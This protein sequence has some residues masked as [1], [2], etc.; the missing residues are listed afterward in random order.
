MARA[1]P[2]A[3]AAVPTLDELAA[4][5]ARA[6]TLPPAVAEALQT[7][8]LLVLNAL[9]GRCLAARA[10]PE[11]AS[12]PD[13][14]IDVTAAAERLGVSRDWLYHHARQLPFTVRQGRLL[15]FSS[16]GINRYIRSRQGRLGGLAL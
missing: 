7:K 9:W 13:S 16:H 3:P 5:P 11:V 1:L 15:R 10:T 14:L 12:E 4:D 8:C 2:I 6:T